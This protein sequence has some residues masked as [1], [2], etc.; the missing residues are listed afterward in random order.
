MSNSTPLGTAMLIALGGAIGTISRYGAQTFI[1]KL[2][3]PIS[4]PLGTFLVNI[5][6]CFIIGLIY[7]YSEK[8]NILAP[9]WKLFLTT[10]I[11]G[12]F[13][14]FSTFAY[15]SIGLI[16]SANLLYLSLYTLG[17]VALGIFAVFLGMAF[18]RL[19]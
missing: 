3:N 17:S 7:G 10:G 1:F 2:F 5:V 14:T 6:G 4:F 19:T 15:E 9:E 18:V 16:R 12:G 13:T 11:C 8:V